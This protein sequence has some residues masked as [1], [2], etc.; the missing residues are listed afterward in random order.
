MTGRPDCQVRKATTNDAAA[1]VELNRSFNG[2]AHVE[3]DPAAVQRSLERL[4]DEIVWVADCGERLAGFVCVQIHRSFCYARQSLEI[5]ELY[6]LPEARRS[7]IGTKLL[8]EVLRFAADEN[9][10]EM[11]LRVNMKN[12]AAIRFYQANGLSE[13]KHRVFRVRLYGS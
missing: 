13:A 10:L 9:V 12:K 1:L 6:V 5:T 8:Q 2:A 3:T 11:N 7:R 4:T